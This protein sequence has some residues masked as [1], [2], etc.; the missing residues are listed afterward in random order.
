MN[1][2][3]HIPKGFL[4]DFVDSILFMSGSGTGVAFQRMNQT[5]IINM[6]PN[7]R[8][9]DIYTPAPK[10]NELTET[11]WINGKQEIPFMLEHDGIM[12]MYVIGV[13]PGMLPY[14][15]DLPAIETNEM[16][17]GAE[18]WGS[19][20]IYHLREQLQECANTRL[21]LLLIEQYLEKWLL[22]KDFLYLD[23]IKWLGKTLHT[24]TV[25]ELCQSLGMTRKRLRSEAQHYFGDSIKNIQGIARF[26]DTLHDI[27]HK[28]HQSLSSVHHYY[29]Q[30]HF[31][32]D[33]KARCGITPLQYKKLCRLYPDIK[34]TPNFISLQRETFLQFISAR[35]L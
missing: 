3:V 33:F 32:N 19:K 26:N 11:I 24:H 27:A 30:S 18:N 2:E 4:K 13:K 10:R 22:K 16:A 8:V 1:I 6:G 29:D 17:V 23:K 15:A 9:S 35:E 28:A 7:F 20:E 25:G 5:I 12:A 21:G 34:Y 31:I 14:L